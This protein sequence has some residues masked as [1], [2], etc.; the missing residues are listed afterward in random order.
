MVSGIHNDNWLARQNSVRLFGRCCAPASRSSNTTAPCC[1]TRRWWWTACGAT[2]G[3]TNFDNRS[4]AHNEENNVCFY[5][6]AFAGALQK[7][8]RADVPG[9]DPV[10]LEA[11]TRRGL[12]TRA[13]ETLAALMEEQS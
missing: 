8:F 7:M 6:R 13:Q 11:W 1:T 4:F 9:C 12:W 10:A 3:T 5:D 2:V